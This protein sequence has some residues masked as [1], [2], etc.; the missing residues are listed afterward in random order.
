MGKIWSVF[1]IFAFALVLLGCQN[2]V[3]QTVQDTAS[4]KHGFPQRMGSTSLGS[5]QIS[6]V[7][8]WLHTLVLESDGTVWSFGLNT[9]GELGDGTTDE[10]HLPSSVP[11]CSGITSIAT[12]AAHSV[13]LKNDGTVWAWGYNSYGQLGDGTTETRLSPIQI[14]G[15]SEVTAIAT[16]Q[17]HALALK[18]DGTV[19]AWGSNEDGQLGDGTT[20]DR[21]S[22]VQVTALSGTCAIAA[23]YLHS[24]ALKQDGTCYTWG[25]ND[26]GELGNGSTI[27]C[28]TPAQVPG[29]V[30]VV[31]IRV[32]FNFT[33]TLRDDGTVWSWGKN[34]GGCL[35]DGTYETRYSPVQASGL[36]GVTSIAAGA[37][38]SIAKK[39]DGTVWAWGD[40]KYGQIGYGDREPQPTPVP[41]TF[42]VGFL[43]DFIEIGAGGAQSFAVG[44]NGTM[45]AWGFNGY[46][47]LGDGTTTDRWSPVRIVPLIDQDLVI[48]NLSDTFFYGWQRLNSVLNGYL[49]GGSV[50]TLSPTTVTH[51]HSVT[52]AQSLAVTVRGLQFTPRYA[53]AAHDHDAPESGYAELKAEY[54]SLVPYESTAVSDLFL[55][56]GT[57]LFWDQAGALPDGW[58]DA[59]ELTGSSYTQPSRTRF[60]YLKTGASAIGGNFY[61]SHTEGATVFEMFHSSFIGTSGFIE[62]S[63]DLLGAHVHSTI[64]LNS[65]VIIPNHVVLRPMKAISATRM[66]PS[67]AIAFFKKSST[68]APHGWSMYTAATGRNIGVSDTVSVGTI[69][70]NTTSIRSHVHSGTTSVFSGSGT[71]G[72][73]PSG[74]SQVQALPRSHS[75]SVTANAP[76]GTWRTV[77]SPYVELMVCKKD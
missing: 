19:W 72:T 60:I 15:L 65:T 1:Y 10:R 61:H 3:L 66:I 38:H 24:I 20:I 9:N 39:S 53:D 13:V 43:S 23:G 4:Q 56:A 71:T 35:G 8:S 2:P 45:W 11:G 64:T 52:V 68:G 14:A 16:G 63:R 18:S 59:A 77:A 75:H 27:D 28:H 73:E 12:G 17:N 7:A 74:S 29:L 21:H 76:G 62:L 25:G 44:N 40:N 48:F 34:V 51:K 49:E 54:A 31:G 42:P 41:V 47:Q 50:A 69:V 67:G 58:Q 33:M 70:N 57:V 55:P 30:G 36:T 26:S 46:G 32:G 5:V 37:Y 6:S 22:P